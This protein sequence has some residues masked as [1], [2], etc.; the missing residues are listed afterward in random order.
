MAGSFI[1][2]DLGLDVFQGGQRLLALAQE[3]D[4][5]HP[6]VLVVTDV[7][8]GKGRSRG[9]LAVG[10][11][12]TDPPQ[13]RLVADD[14]AL[15]AGQLPWRKPSAL[16]HVLD[17]DRLVVD[18]GDDQAADF[19]DPAQFLR[20]EDGG[21]GGRALQPQHLVHR[22]QAAAKQADAPHRH[23]NLALVEVVAAHRGVAVGQR[24]L[25]LTQRDAVAAEA[26]GV[27][28]N[29]VAPHRAAEAGDVHDP[30]HRPE[31]ALQHPV[32]HRLDVVE[33]VDLAAGSILGDFQDIAEDFAGGRLRRDGR[34]HV[35][36]QRLADRG[37]A[38]DHFLPSRLVGVVAAVVPGH[39]EVAEAEQRLAVDLLQ[40]G[41]AGERHFQ[42]DGDL[43]LDLL[44]GCA[45][46]ERDHFDD[47]RRRV[48]VGFDVD[49]QEGVRRR[50]PR[51]RWPAG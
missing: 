7:V 14:H 32:L 28:L 39:L 19:P 38:V 50:S 16:D 51:G 43:P 11:P 49:V 13:P 47:R 34:G 10:A 15:F 33:R 41:H 22:V 29:L 9:P 35:G 45:G 1:C 48:G 25:E 24:R 42:G 3:H 23:G 8:E 36:R 26:V 5:R 6:V 17:A 21:G 40:A 2:C 44:G 46:E 20:A 12:I 37:H 27:G 31:L 4:A 18:R 30:R